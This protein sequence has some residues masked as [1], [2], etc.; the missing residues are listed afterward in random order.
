MD[1]KLGFDV[2]DKHNLI[3]TNNIT[4]MSCLADT[5]YHS[6]MTVNFYLLKKLILNND[7]VNNPQIYVYGSDKFLKRLVSV[8]L[9]ELKI[10]Q[11]VDISIVER[12]L[13]KFLERGTFTIPYTNV[14]MNKKDFN[15]DLL[16]EKCNKILIFDDKYFKAML[17][18][19]QI[20]KL[21]KENCA[22]IF[23]TKFFKNYID[24][25]FEKKAQEEFLDISTIRNYFDVIVILANLYMDFHH[26]KD[27]LTFEISKDDKQE[28][29]TI[30]YDIGKYKNQ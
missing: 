17:E 7:I 2:L 22:T 14:N 29:I 6:R 13:D 5:D 16:D 28:L 21:K 8:I 15:F 24:W 19:G 27:F 4:L 3:R 25:A 9:N 11:K 30:P 10:S 18:Q 12:D 20:H 1:Y 26:D 23:L